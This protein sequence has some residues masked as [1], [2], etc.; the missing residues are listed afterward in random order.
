MLRKT[1][2][3]L[4][5]VS[6]AALGA[7]APATA[8]AAANG[9]ITTLEPGT[10]KVCLYA[11]FAPFASKVNGQWQG[12]DV[13]Y[14]SAFAAASSLKFVVVEHDF[15]GI[16]LA[17]GQK[18]CDVAGT[19]ISDIA[20]RRQAAGKDAVWSN[21][22][23]G[24][25]RTFL[26]RTEQ[27]ANLAKVEDLRGRKA[28]ITKGSTAN[29]D[30][31]YRMAA[32]KLHPCVKPGGD[33]PCTF[34]GFDLKPAT[35]KSCVDIEY[36]Q[37]ND[38][39]KAASA[40]ANSGSD[41]S[42]FTYG[43]GYGSVQALVC[44]WSDTQRLATVWPHCNMSSNGINAYAEAFSFVVRAADAGLANALNCFIGANKYAGTPIP[45][46][47]CQ[48]PPWTPPPAACIK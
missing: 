12:W 35:D 45:D 1:C 38:E 48:R 37:D 27:F 21:T 41:Y 25:V 18:L 43:G 20:E 29:T 30:L 10:L 31:C 26:V 9:S 6:A 17:P 28:I 14:L 22:Y 42:P 11:G 39:G 44:Q 2:V 15:N 36:P 47:G 33:Q 16:W 7:A 3:A 24:V 13:D 32:R 46:L 8:H 23:Y 19:G 34:P 40:V 5:L 4:L